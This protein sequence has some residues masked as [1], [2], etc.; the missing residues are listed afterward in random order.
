MN[1]ISM[2][3]CLTLGAS[4]SAMLAASTA[5]AQHHDDGHH[6]STPPAEA[7]DERIGDPYPLDTCPITGKELG[8]MG[9]PVVKLYDGREIR[10]CCAGCPAK[11]EADLEANLAEIDEAIREDQRPLYPVET[12]IVSDKALPEEPYEFV[13]GNRLIRLASEDERATFLAHAEE[14]LEK[15]N[16]AVIKA[17]G[18]HYPVATCPVSGDEFGGDMG[19]PVDLVIGGRLIRMCCKGC[20]R[21]VEEN[22]A[23]FIKMVDEARESHDDALAHHGGGC[24]MAAA[25]FG[26]GVL[27]AEQA[28]Q[29]GFI[30]PLTGEQLPCPRCCPL[31]KDQ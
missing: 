5:M 15:L 13:Y 26:M 8:S 6:H 30:C 2:T 7:A 17:Q 14:Y 9:D 4:A 18:A 21:D 3:A 16:E 27:P 23:K 10:F 31:N 12:S 1:A 28:S 19:E 24:L 11:F 29:G 25:P 22:P 20:R